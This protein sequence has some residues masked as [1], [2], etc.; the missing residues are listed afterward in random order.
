[1]GE[2]KNETDNGPETET[3]NM[4]RKAANGT[5]ARK[6][7]QRTKITLNALIGIKMDPHTF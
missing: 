1:M 5:E 3:R 6:T 7:E 2:T 4:K